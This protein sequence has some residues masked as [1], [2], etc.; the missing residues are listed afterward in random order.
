[1]LRYEIQ[2]L[3]RRSFAHIKDRKARIHAAECELVRQF[4]ATQPTGRFVEV[5]ANH[6]VRSSQTWH[7]EQAGW[8]GVLVE[9][10]PRLCDE[11]RRH[12]PHST[13]V[14]TACGTPQN[15]GETDFF[16]HAD[17]ARSSL[18]PDR[19][20]QSVSTVERIRVP[21]RTLDDI[22][23]NLDLSQV[24]FVSIDVE[25]LQLDV[26]RGFTA[27]R[28]QPRLLLV[29]DHLTNLQTHRYLTARGYRL[30]KR[31]VR[32]NWYVPADAPFELSTPGERWLL[33]RRVWLDTP[34]RWL[35]RQWNRLFAADR[36]A[37]ARLDL[38]QWIAG[39]PADVPATRFTKPVGQQDRPAEQSPVSDFP[40]HTDHTHSD[41][42][43]L[44]Q[45]FDEG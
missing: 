42:E 39:N 7:L 22:L 11:L 40:T 41:P 9:P 34:V 31:T 24:D 33:W 37:A 43:R 25:G 12:R 38:S 29:E 18:E 1:M 10:I 32:N 16:V 13:V 28:F 26:L 21:V 2:R 20:V 30:V 14:G 44:V 8:T 6:P 4:F 19:L 15:R 5:G 17:P 27:E 36:P 23:D 35:R 3:S 45:Q